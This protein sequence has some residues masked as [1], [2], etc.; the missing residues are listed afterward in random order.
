MT[1][2]EFIRLHVIV[3][4]HVQGVGFRFFVQDKAN[5]LDIRG[6][7]RNRWDGTVEVIAEGVSENLDSLV[8]AFYQGT[9]ASTVTNIKTERQTAT[10]EFTHFNIRLTSN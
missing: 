10:G 4:G 1:I 5:S 8:H 3:E 7:V 2:D 6:W 9:M